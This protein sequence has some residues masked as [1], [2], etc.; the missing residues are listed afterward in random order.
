MVGEMEGQPLKIERG[1][2]IYTIP[3]NR[4]VYIDPSTPESREETKKGRIEDVLREKGLRIPENAKTVVLHVKNP[5]TDIRVVDGVIY[6]RPEETELWSLIGYAGKKKKRTT[7]QKTSLGVKETQLD[8][9]GGFS[10]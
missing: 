6:A 5:E 3:V 4:F 9:G 10:K 1:K 2:G 7:P 8:L